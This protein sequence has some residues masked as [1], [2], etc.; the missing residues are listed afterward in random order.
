[1]KLALLAMM[2]I[3]GTVFADTQTIAG[4]Y[5]VM[6]ETSSFSPCDARESWWLESKDKSVGDELMARYNKA[7]VPKNGEFC[8]G[9]FLKV[10]GQRSEL[11]NYG[12]MG[13]YKRKFVVEEIQVVEQRLDP[14]KQCVEA[15]NTR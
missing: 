1:M 7:C 6:F 14:E 8:L 2:L 10:T 12:H 13:S 5:F 3:P 9:V 11:G 15:S 4:H